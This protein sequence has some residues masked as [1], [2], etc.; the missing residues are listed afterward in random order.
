MEDLI[1][2][3]VDMD[4]KAREITDAAQME[5]VNSEKEVAAKREQIRNEYLERARRRIA[6]NEPKER[7]AAEKEWKEKEKKN[8]FIFQK[9]DKLYTENGDKWVKEIVERVLGSD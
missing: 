2:Q 1:K 3:I 9:L 6:L 8:E 5:K 4:R 7:E